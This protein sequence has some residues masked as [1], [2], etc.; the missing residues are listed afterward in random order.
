MKKCATGANSLQIIASILLLKAR[1]VQSEE[2]RRHLQDA[3]QRVM[4]V[5]TVQEQLRGTGLG[6]SIEIG[7]Y[8]RKLSD[9]IAKSMIAN[10]RLVTVLV[11][12]G[13][14]TAVSA[15]AVSIGL[16]VTELLINAFKH[17]FPDDRPGTIRVGYRRRLDQGGASRLLMMAS[18]ARAQTVNLQ[19]PVWARRLSRRS[20]IN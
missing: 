7:P 20:P 18:G 3:H 16:I 8:L 13:A 17:A 19:R 5:A 15:Q 4:S 10:D 1:T 2:T 14:G 12:A 6:D 11:E 9:S